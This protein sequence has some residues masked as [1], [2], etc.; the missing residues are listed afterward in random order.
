MIPAHQAVPNARLRRQR[1]QRGW[2]LQRVADELQKLSEHEGRRVGV[3]ASMVGKWERG[4]KRPSPFYQEKLCC[5][6]EQTAEELGLV[7]AA[8]QAAP[9]WFDDSGTLADTLESWRHAVERRAF[10]RH[11]SSFAGAAMVAPAIDALGPQ[12]PHERLAQALDRP[13]RVDQATMGHVETVTEQFRRL[14]DRIGSRDLLG[15]VLGHL[16]FI[17]RLLQG[18]QPTQVHHRL[19]VAAAQVAQLAGWLSFDANL[20]AD[21]RAYYDVAV[22]AAD[23]G[24]DAALSAYVLGCRGVVE[25]YGGQPEAGLQF[26]QAA[27][28]RGSAVVTATTQAWLYRVEALAQAALAEADRCSAS[29][30]KAEQAMERSDAAEDPPWIYHF[31]RSQLAGQKGACYVRL[32]RPEAAREALGEAL[33][34][35]SPEFVRDRSLHLTHLAGAFAQQGEIEE[36]CRRAAQSLEIIVQM[37]S[38]RELRRLRELRRE[39]D[40]FAATRAV[41][42]LDAQLLLV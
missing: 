37:G 32:H 18:S 1:L 11:L 38:A 25:I 12:E 14:D 39:L 9:V 21:A 17:T 27:L 30:G 2:S 5:L 8:E 33:T 23:E 31:D 20:H 15:P 6:Y 26:A 35:L 16:R 36:S 22:K 42:D 10:F 24:N 34:T 3:T 19:C 28:Y 29:L 7:D 41:K 4:F 40:P 13:S